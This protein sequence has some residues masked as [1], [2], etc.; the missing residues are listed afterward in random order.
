M[1][2]LPPLMMASPYQHP[3]RSS[4]GSSKCAKLCLEL[5]TVHHPRKSGGAGQLSPLAQIP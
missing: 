4:T 5:P 2:G 3:S 1:V